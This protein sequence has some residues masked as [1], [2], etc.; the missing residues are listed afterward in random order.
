MTTGA[1]GIAVPATA[2]EDSPYVTVA[3]SYAGYPDITA[4]QPFVSVT[5][6]A[7][8][9]A[10]DAL[11]ASPEWCG[12]PLQ[13]DVYQRTDKHG[14]SWES[15]KETGALLYGHDGG[16][17]AYNAGVGTPY[18]VITSE[19]YPCTTTPTPAP[20]TEPT[21][22]PSPTPPLPSETPSPVP[23]PS[24][25]P[26]STPTPSVPV[27]E[28]EPSGTPPVNTPSPSPTPRPSE[29]GTSTHKHGNEPKPQSHTP[30]K[31]PA[32]TAPDL[33][34]AQ[35]PVAVSGSVSFTG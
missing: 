22:T 14:I 33:P 16:Y 7:N 6:G 31:A 11:A 3:W 25:E 13:V 5:P 32:V 18:R 34:A 17:L 10:F 29:P 15:L 30:S 27:T 28:P 12:K 1:L 4:P 19:D 2:T 24:D 23:A 8:L 21:G 20:T 35:V 26:T 9:A